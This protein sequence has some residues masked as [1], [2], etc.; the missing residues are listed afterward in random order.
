MTRIVSSNPLPIKMIEET[1]YLNGWLDA[2]EIEF[3]KYQEMNPK[4]CPWWYGERATLGFFLNAII[5]KENDNFSILQEFDSVKKNHKL[6]GTGDLLVWNKNI[7]YLFEAKKFYSKY[8]SNGEYTPTGKENDLGFIKKIIDQ[9]QQ[10]RFNAYLQITKPKR[11]YTVAICFDTMIINAKSSGEINK[12]LLERWNECDWED[13][14]KNL[15]FYR[16]YS[17]SD[18]SNPVVWKNDNYLYLGM[19]VYG[20]I[21]EMK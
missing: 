7:C 15:H 14:R 17:Y 4:D 21:E 2:L 8:N 10:Y 9:A 19:A 16:F 5:H 1:K 12:C 3:N 18:N 6:R 11:W 20:I 13:Y